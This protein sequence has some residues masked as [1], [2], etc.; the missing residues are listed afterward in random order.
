M[1]LAAVSGAPVLAIATETVRGVR[2]LFAEDWSHPCLLGLAWGAEDLAADLGAMAN[3][4]A[5]GAYLPPF[6]MAR[7][8]MLF[9]ARAAGVAAVDAV[10]T[11]IRDT[12]G[13]RA[14]TRAAETL[15]FTAKMAIHPGQIPVIHAAL[16]PSADRV[17]WARRVIEA[18]E[19]AEGG[20]ALLDGAMLDQPHLRLARSILAR[21]GPGG[22][23]G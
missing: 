6:Q 18:L 2:A 15:G 16:A 5:D 19:A 14:E 4:G 12:D 9:A 11:D 7:D 13:L 17:T 20:V 1:H 8:A 3:R 22:D 21:S 10:Y 23:P